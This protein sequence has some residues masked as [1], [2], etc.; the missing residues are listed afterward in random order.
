MREEGQ[1]R[2]ESQET[3]NEAA[4]SVALSLSL[5]CCRLSYDDA[6][7]QPTLSE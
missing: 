5:R 2:A 6:G 1:G 7:F 4:V 3:V